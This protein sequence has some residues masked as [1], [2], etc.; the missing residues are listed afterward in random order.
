MQESDR[1]SHRPDGTDGNGGGPGGAQRDEAREGLDGARRE[2]ER[3]RERLEEAEQNVRRAQERIDEAAG[4]AGAETAADSV[5]G[6]R[7]GGEF[8]VPPDEQREP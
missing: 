5:T 2:L 7:D 4:L 8:L 6:P 3:A 1:E